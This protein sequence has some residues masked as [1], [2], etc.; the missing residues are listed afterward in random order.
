MPILSEHGVSA[1]RPYVEGVVELIKERATFVADFWDIAKYL[2]IAPTEYE[3]KDVDKFW[4]AE[5]IPYC[6][7][8]CQFIT[9]SYAGPWT[10]EALEPAMVDYIK[11]REYP[12]GKVMNSLR[13]ALT[14]AASGLGIAAILSFIGREEFARRMD[15]AGAKL[16]RFI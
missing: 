7:E 10:A 11:A 3:Q 9:E 14:G 15:A 6:Y 13:L 5:H 12:M 8:L 1:S 16:G 4:K 2:F